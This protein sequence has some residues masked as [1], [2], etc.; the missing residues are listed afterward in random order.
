MG[1]FNNGLIDAIRVGRGLRLEDGDS[2]AGGPGT[3]DFLLSEDDG[4]KNNKYGVCI[5]GYGP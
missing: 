5:A 2:G 4:T 1:N 3:F